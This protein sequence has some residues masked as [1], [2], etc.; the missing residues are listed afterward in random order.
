MSCSAPGKRSGGLLLHERI[1][2]NFFAIARPSRLRNRPYCPVVA[3]PFLEAKSLF[4]RGFDA[5]LFTLHAAGSL[6]RYHGN[7]AD[8]QAFA[9]GAP[10]PKPSIAITQ[11]GGRDATH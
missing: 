6:C 8:R 9:I 7:A 10:P 4:S 1:D 3:R 2:P 11:K 5:F